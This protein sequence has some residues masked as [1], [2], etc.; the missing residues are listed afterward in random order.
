MLA[1]GDASGVSILSSETFDLVR[2]IHSAEGAER[3]ALFRDADRTLFAFGAFDEIARFDLTVKGTG[4]MALPVAGITSLSPFGDTVSVVESDGSVSFWSARSGEQI[5]SSDLSIS[6]VGELDH[7]HGALSGMG[8]V[9]VFSADGALLYLRDRDG[10]FSVIEVSSG[11][12]VGDVRLPV[13]RT[14]NALAVTASSDFVATGHSDGRVMLW[15]AESF[16]TTDEPLGAWQ[17]FGDVG[18]CIRSTQPTFDGIR[19][20][21]VRQSISSLH[22]SVVDQCGMATTWEVVDGEP[23]SLAGFANSL[24]LDFGPD[25][26][27]LVSQLGTRF[28]LLA[29]DG[30][31]IR[32]FE[33]HREDIV[34]TSSSDDLS[35]IASVSGD[36]IGLWYTRTGQSLASGVTGAQAH[37]AGDG[38]FAVTSGGAGFDWFGGPVVVWDLDPDTWKEHACSAAG[39]NFSLFEWRQ[40]YPDDAYRVTCP[41]WPS[42]LGG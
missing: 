34:Q 32:S 23:T 13:G 4:S 41:Q 26:S 27:N 36:M 42:G 39:R 17:L 33:G 7:S 3:I 1:I 19:R 10:R 38:T 40:F 9:P 29:D 21:S 20:L 25:E 16:G 15:D 35:T 24:A 12:V 6:E 8:G 28:R 37:I 14:H 18:S 2:R 11:D 31:E 5:G 22:L 30:T